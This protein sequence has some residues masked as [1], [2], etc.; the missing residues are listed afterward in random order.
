MPKISVVIP[1]YNVEKYLRECLDSVINQSF[2]NWECICVNDGSTDNSLDIL[3]EYAKKDS[4]IQIID[5]KN[6]GIAFARNQGIKSANSEYITFL[7]SDDAMHHQCLE[8]ML[9]AIEDADIC[10]CQYQTFSGTLPH[11]EEII[12]DRKIIIYSNPFEDYLNHSD[13]LRPVVWNKL[14][15]T[16]MVQNCLF[17]E[18]LRG[19]EDYEWTLRIFYQATKVVYFPQKLINYRKR[20]GS[21]TGS[22]MSDA[23]IE[24]NL[25]CAAHAMLF[26]K[27]K[28]LA[29]P[30]QKKLF[31]KL[32]KFTF[33]FA[34]LKNPIKKGDYSSWK[35]Y[36]SVLS[37]MEKDGTYAPQYLSIKNQIKSTLFCRQMFKLLKLII[38]I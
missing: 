27:E 36:A 29:L 13:D 17:D 15:K 18:A 20:A 11:N 4:R 3:Q 34:C 26:F 19:T 21:I 2:S 30:I 35:K 10:S 28:N 16:Q 25:L 1:V 24:A 5:Q 23:Y 12:N 6:G 9:A 33:K 31:A 37:S 8:L 32:A 14:Y 22:G 7:D 38:R